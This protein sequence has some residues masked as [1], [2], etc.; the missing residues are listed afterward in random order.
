M[1]VNTSDIWPFAPICSTSEDGYGFTDELDGTTTS[2]TCTKQE[3]IDA[4]DKSAN[5]SQFESHMS[6]VFGAHWDDLPD[7]GS[8]PAKNVTRA[9][10]SDVRIAMM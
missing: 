7:T 5:E 9:A 10:F 2:S 4:V 1:G 8:D 3:W 6:T